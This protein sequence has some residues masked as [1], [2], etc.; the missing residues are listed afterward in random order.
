LGRHILAFVVVHCFDFLVND[1]FLY[2]FTFLDGGGPALLL[3]FVVIYSSAH[4]SLCVHAF[5]HDY[6]LAFLLIHYLT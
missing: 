6:V 4:L 5:G 1:S 2:C 3:Q